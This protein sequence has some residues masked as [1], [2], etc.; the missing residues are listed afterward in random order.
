M[1]KAEQVP[2]DLARVRRLLARERAVDRGAW[3]RLGGW[4]LSAVAAVTIAAYAYD[5]SGGFRRDNA[6]SADLVRELRGAQQ[7]LQQ[8][9]QATA[10]TSQTEAKR[11]AAA[12]G[13]L[14][15]DRDRLYTRVST[16]EQ[17]LDS[18]TGSLSRQAAALASAT[19]VAPVAQ[20]APSPAPAP[21]PA[22]MPE[23]AAQPVETK[24]AELAA[25]MSATPAETA[26]ARTLFG[27]DL[28]AAPNLDG[29]RAI[30]RREAAA[31]TA[32][33]SLQPVVAVRDRG[34][35][36]GVALHL[37]AGPLNDAAAAA[38]L[39]AALGPREKGCE[40]AIYDGQR[41]ALETATPLPPRKRPKVARPPPAA[42][43]A[44]A[45]SGSQPR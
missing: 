8:Q 20:A 27:V 41:L 17:S 45:P 11:L 37:V 9:L 29:L 42:P 18:V 13:T 32:V 36:T 25:A 15:S 33:A 12:I 28:G 16:L 2:D 1:A 7:A 23:P 24:P 30:W 5:V 35:P 31:S 14:N 3:L 34:L 10:Q 4:G 21:P 19:T 44:L 22:A 26:A 39:C 43:V 6:T 38:K 40:P